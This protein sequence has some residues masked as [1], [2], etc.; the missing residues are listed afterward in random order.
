MASC[1][2]LNLGEP[3]LEVEDIWPNG[4]AP[5]NPTPEDVVK[6]MARSGGGACV[7]A[8]EWNLLDGIEVV[9]PTGETAVYR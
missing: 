8:R 4:D 9:G 7:I 3:V 1:F 6:Q 5:E 2:T